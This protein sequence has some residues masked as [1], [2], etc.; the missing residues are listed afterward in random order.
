MSERRYCMAVTPACPNGPHLA[1]HEHHVRRGSARKNAPTVAL[2]R[3]AHEWVHAH[4]AEARELGL[5][6]HAPLP[7]KARLFTEIDEP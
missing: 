7:E 1:E 2:C 5:Y 4:P 3:E 6:E